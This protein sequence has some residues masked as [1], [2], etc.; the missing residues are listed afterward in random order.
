MCKR[1]VMLPWTT[2]QNLGTIP[3]LQGLEHDNHNLLCYMLL[4]AVQDILIIST[5]NVLLLR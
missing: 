1:S 2:P 5:Y 4:T 3:T